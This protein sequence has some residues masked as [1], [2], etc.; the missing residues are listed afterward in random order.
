MIKPFI[1][2]L[3]IRI[4]IPTGTVYWTI[5]NEV[6]L[7]GAGS[8]EAQNRLDSQRRAIDDAIRNATQWRVAKVDPILK[9]YVDP[10]KLQSIQI[11]MPDFVQYWNCGVRTVIRSIAEFDVKRT[12]GKLVNW[13]EKAFQPKVDEKP[14]NLAAIKKPN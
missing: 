6:W 1:N 2:F 13:S 12:Y 14:S 11:S 3:F 8:P 10:S 4:S 5:V 9:P 7:P